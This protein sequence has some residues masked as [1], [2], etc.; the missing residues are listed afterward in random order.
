MVWGSAVLCHTSCKIQTF[1]LEVIKDHLA[2]FSVGTAKLSL[3]THASL[4][5]SILPVSYPFTFIWVFG[6]ILSMGLV[7]A[8]KQACQDPA[9]GKATLVKVYPL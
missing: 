8:V 1:L 5:L 4:N 6:V 7:C 2:A 9:E 3:W